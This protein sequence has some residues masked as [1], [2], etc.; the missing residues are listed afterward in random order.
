MN[1]DLK[2]PQVLKSKVFTLSDG[3][4]YRGRRFSCGIEVPIVAVSTEIKFPNQSDLDDRPVCAIEC[5]SVNEFTNNSAQYANLN[6]TCF[7]KGVLNLKFN[8]CSI[9]EKV[10]LPCLNVPIQQGRLYLIDDLIID[11]TTCNVTFANTTGLV[12]TESI[13]FI[14]HYWD[15]LIAI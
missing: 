10:P 7:K 9:I 15:D 4:S 2:F 5:V 6:D 8:K 14:V 13:F 11:W 12:T 1:S 3:R